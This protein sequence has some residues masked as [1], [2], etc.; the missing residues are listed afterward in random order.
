ML[1]EAGKAPPGYWLTVPDDDS[2]RAEFVMPEIN[3]I[4]PPPGSDWLIKVHKAL[5][6]I[7]YP[8]MLEDFLRQAHLDGIANSGG[9]GM[10]DGRSFL[11][12]T[13]R[14]E[15]DSPVR[16]EVECYITTPDG[17]AGRKIVHGAEIAYWDAL[18]NR[19]ILK[20]GSW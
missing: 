11:T 9:G 1:Q 12:Y 15:K 17:W 20:D 6:K 3:L 19:Y 10:P 16:F 7:T 18:L 13:L 14:S 4:T 8:V 5:I 2:G